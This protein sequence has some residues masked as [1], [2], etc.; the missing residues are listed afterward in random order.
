MRAN[1]R[2]VVLAI[3]AHGRV[4]AARGRCDA[5]PDVTTLRPLDDWFGAAAPVV[6]DLCAAARKSDVPLGPQRVVLGDGGALVELEAFAAT[7]DD[8]TVT[9]AVTDVGA[10]DRARR[11]EAALAELTRDVGFVVAADG[12]V[13][14]A[15]AP[16]ARLLAHDSLRGVDLAALV[17]PSDRGR[18]LS[19]VAAP[20]P[21]ES[22]FSVVR[23]RAADG[24]DRV[25]EL[26]AVRVALDE[27][28][29][30]GHDVTDARADA[31]LLDA[32]RRVLDLLVD[33]GDL[34]RALDAVG[35]FV[36]ERTA[37]GCAALYR[38]TGDALMLSAAPSLSPH[39]ARAL[40]TLPLDEADPDA[41]V[42]LPAGMITAA[43][44][45]RVGVGWLRVAAV[46][47]RVLG[48]VALLVAGGRRFATRSERD[49]LDAAASLAAVALAHTVRT[50][51]TR[52]GDGAGR[53]ALTGL[54]ARDAFLAALEGRRTAGDVAVVLVDVRGLRGLNETVGPAAGDEVLRAVA[55]ALEQGRRAR[56]VLGRLDGTTFALAASVRRGDDGA[57]I[58]E[59]VGAAVRRAVAEAP[60]G[61]V[62]DVA[63]ATPPPGGR[64]L[65]AVVAADSELGRRHSGRDIASLAEGSRS[66][67]GADLR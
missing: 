2:D 10:Y 7:D 51:T 19:L 60:G 12:T 31:A 46:G 58:A 40:R 53:D 1:R 6:A 33:A 13:L 38:W 4:V 16:A 57:T 26:R 56:D 30:A 62:A 36:E 48:A 66:G 34:T 65:D 25:V 59:R 45:L 32:H 20:A 3:D 23:M 9:L 44:D 29:L 22:G 18:L 14:D 67:T 54:L 42:P 17:A 15:T 47:E 52:D 24:D 35:R 50:Q 37:S 63:V 11:R 43:A 39:A 27:V 61:V 55:R 5:L 28:V 41:L 49:A 21:E 64:P 8:T